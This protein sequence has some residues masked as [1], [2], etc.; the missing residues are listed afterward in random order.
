MNFG[1]MNWSK[2]EEYLKHD[3]RVMLVLGACE[4]HATL[5]LLTDSKIPLALAEAARADI[6]DMDRQG[7]GQ[8]PAGWI[9]EPEPRLLPKGTPA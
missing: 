2:I 5:S 9:E 6:G 3:D 1:E 4:Q 7:S 8:R